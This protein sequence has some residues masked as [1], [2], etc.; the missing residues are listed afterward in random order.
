MFCFVRHGEANYKEKN[1]KIYQGFGVNLSPLSETGVKQ[2]EE[3]AKDAR[4][5]NADII[6]SSPFT[7]ALQTAAVLSKNLGTEIV[8]ETD[9]HEWA[10]DKNYHYVDDSEAQKRYREFEDGDGKYP[11]GTECLWEDTKCMR[12]RVLA[13]LN[14]YRHYNKVI[15]ACHEMVIYA[16]TGK[17]RSDNGE[18]TEFEL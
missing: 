2:I 14:R 18:I 7:R 16:V 11:D 13:V 10:A 17:R 5:K 12:E 9:L 1:N 3:T 4:L 6:L 8:V 15:V